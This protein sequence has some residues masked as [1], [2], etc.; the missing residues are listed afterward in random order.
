MSHRERVEI[1]EV[2]KAL[3]GIKV[4]FSN[5][6]VASIG[7]KDLVLFNNLG[8]TNWEV[9]AKFEITKGLAKKELNP[10]GTNIFFKFK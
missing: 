5:G 4:T 1:K 10:L 7:K 2:N 3:D 8:F 6:T 9:G